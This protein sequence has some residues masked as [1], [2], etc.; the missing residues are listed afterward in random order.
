[1][2]Q[3]PSEFETTVWLLPPE[4]EVLTLDETLPFP[5]FM[6][7]ELP[8]LL[9]AVTLPP[10]AVTE[11]DTDPLFSAGG[12]SRSTILQFLLSSASA[13]MVGRNRKSA[14]RDTKRRFMQ[15]SWLMQA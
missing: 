10:P 11:D 12:E 8:P 4:P 13:T 14:V 5:E 6:V 9:C 2:V 15:A 1:M 3:L 7:M